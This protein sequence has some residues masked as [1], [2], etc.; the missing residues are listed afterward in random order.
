[1]VT[2][3]NALTKNILREIT[4]SK[5]RF[6]SILII[7]A[8][9]VAFFAGVRATSPEMKFTADKYLDDNNTADLTIQS[10]NG[11]KQSD[12]DKVKKIVGVSEVYGGYSFDAL[13]IND[14]SEKAIKIHSL[15]IGEKSANNPVLVDGAM[16]TN[17]GEAVTEKTYLEK[18]NLKIGDYIKI[19]TVNGTK[20]FKITGIVN[21]PL[22]INTYQRGAN[23]LGNGSTSGFFQIGE[24]SAKELALPKIPEIPGIKIE[25]IYTELSIVVD[26]AKSKNTFLDEYK[27]LVN[28]VKEKIEAV[29]KNWY[30]KTRDSNEGI[31][32]FQ[33]DS[34]RIKAIGTAFPLIFF[35]VATLVCLTTMTRMVEE[36]RIQIGTLKALGY[37][38]FSIVSQYFI[39]AF[40]ASVIGSIIGVILGFKIFPFLIFN[41]YRIM[42][43][44]PPVAGNFH[45][46]L[47]ITSALVAI[48]CT[49]LAAVGASIKELIVVPAILMRPKAPKAGKRILLERVKFI[50]KRMSFTEKVTARNIFRYKKRFFMTIIGVAGCTA[51]LI[52]GF[53]LKDSIVA[54]TE[55][56]FGE[57]YTYDLKGYL[58]ESIQEDKEYLFMDELKDYNEIE[59]SLLSFEKNIKVKNNNEENF[60]VEGYILIPKDVDKLGE[61]I[62][63]REE[64]RK[65]DIGDN[66]VVITKK[67]SKLLNIKE[68]DNIEISLDDKTVNAKVNH[69]T[70]HYV[71]HY[72]YMSPK[73]YEKLFDDKVNY[74]AFS[75]KLKNG[76]I[77]QEDKLS[78]EMM[79]NP[80]IATI[81]ST[82]S[83]SDKFKKTMDSVDSV[84][85]V[86]IVSAAALAYV[87]M[88]NLTN[89]NISERMREL[90]TIKVLGF[91]DKEVAGYVYRE[92]IILSIIGTLAGLILGVFL[93]KYVITTAETDMVMFS[94]EIKT[95]SFVYSSIL[96]IVF[97]SLVNIVMYKRL[98]KINMVE[99]L[100]SAE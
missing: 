53:G 35:L 16:P 94:R 30:I 23:S 36:H 79:K 73:Y 98:K 47:A 56:Q 28:E 49:T 87:V 5:S 72:V 66:G 39:Y 45:I 68:G 60:S 46:D 90:A 19:K 57:I 41:A 8:I 55:K 67:L 76:D 38:K 54:V 75:S 69:I 2:M 70:E 50:W 88:Y 99:S 6:L 82:T 61:F 12:I 77:D 34:D 58:R 10:L 97:S 85:L 9:G 26:D 3:K 13:A 33:D 59:D 27:D 63:L 71:S 78:K 18:E 100:K 29:D 1:M 44:I 65:I 96:T 11:F 40:T 52:T 14:D 62:N 91:Y 21:S 74:N 20:D 31:R 17:E 22:Y 92:N 93:H 25:D 32:G 89:I 42:Y 86:L 81:N 83:I 24:K 64:N 80:K 43:T 84:V 51:L 4:K 48:F 7:V 37:S 15:K 95:M